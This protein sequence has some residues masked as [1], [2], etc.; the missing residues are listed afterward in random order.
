MVVQLVRTLPCHGRGRGFESRPPRHSF[1]FQR[2]FVSGSTASGSISAGPGPAL[3]SASPVHPCQPS[4]T[5]ANNYSWP[6][7][8][9]PRNSGPSPIH[10]RAR[11]SDGSVNC[12]S[13]PSRALLDPFSRSFE[14]GA[15]LL[16]T[17]LEQRRSLSLMHHGSFASFHVDSQCLALAVAFVAGNAAMAH[18]ATITVLTDSSWLAKSTS[19][20]AGWNTSPG[21]DTAADSGWQSAVVVSS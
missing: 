19:P 2:S 10:P 1:G 15:R 21:F 6:T 7:V 5:L 20:G 4:L 17:Q 14:L 12:R 11:P 8:G 13:M 16:S 3:D 9:K 18:A